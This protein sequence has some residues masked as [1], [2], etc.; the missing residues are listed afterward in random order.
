MPPELN[1]ALSLAASF[2]PVNH[3]RKMPMA[4][5][6]VLMSQPFIVTSAVFLTAAASFAGLAIKD[7][8]PRESLDTPLIPT[9]P[10]ML[11][12][13]IVAMMA[14]AVMMGLLR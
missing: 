14:L 6:I 12:S 1:C 11:L 9:I 4:L 2:M 13:G 5:P 8:R 3:T 7:R 10:L